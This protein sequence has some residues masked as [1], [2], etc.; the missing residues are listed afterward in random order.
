MSSFRPSCTSLF[1]GF[2]LAD[3]KDVAEEKKEEEEEEH[4]SHD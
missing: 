2:R 1:A 3:D 4:D